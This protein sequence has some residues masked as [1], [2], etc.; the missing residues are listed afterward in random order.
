MSDI[1]HHG[2]PR[3]IP[4]RT[5]LADSFGAF[6]HLLVL[7]WQAWTRDG[8]RSIEAKLRDGGH[9]SLQHGFRLDGTTFVVKR[10]DGSDFC[11]LPASRIK[12][13]VDKGD[14]GYA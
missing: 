10:S 7:L 5:H 11:R 4:L 12:Q 6:A 3:R 8:V 2:A 1:S 13:I 9:V 14:Y